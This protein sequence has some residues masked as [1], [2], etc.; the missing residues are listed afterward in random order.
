M[1]TSRKGDTTKRAQKHQNATAYKAGRYGETR[2]MKLAASVPLAGICAR[3]KEKIEWKKK[4]DKYKPLTVPKRCIIC[5][6]KK[7]KQAYYRLCQGCAETEGVCAKCGGKTE[8]V[9]RYEKPHPLGVA[10]IDF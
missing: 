6:E 2:Q 1:S 3:C 5:Q 7:V 9:S 8:I 10:C 4:Y